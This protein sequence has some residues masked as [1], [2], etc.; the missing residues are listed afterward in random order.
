M[1]LDYYKILEIS[2]HATLLEIKRAYRKL[3]R[4][5][6]PD[7]NPDDPTARE[8]FQA[9][10][11]AYEVL[12]DAKKRTEYD[13]QSQTYQTHSYSSQ[14]SP[15]SPLTAQDYYELGLKKMAKRQ[16]IAAVKDYTQAIAIQPNFLTAYLQRCE[17][18]FYLRFYP[19][20]LE[21]CYQVLSRD[22]KQWQAYY[23]Q[24]R[25]RQKLGYLKAAVEAYT[26]AIIINTQKADLYYY[27]GL[28]HQELNRRKLA[29][30]DFI[31][32]ANLYKKQQN[33][34]GYRQAL[35]HKRDLE[36]MGFIIKVLDI[37]EAVQLFKVIVCTI[38]QVSLNPSGEI[39]P[40]FSQLNFYQ[41]V[42]IGVFY[43]LMAEVLAAITLPNTQ[44]LGIVIWGL[45]LIELLI[46]NCQTYRRFNSLATLFLAGL[47]SLSLSFL[48]TVYTYLSYFPQVLG[49]GLLI[50]ISTS[51]FLILYCGL[52]QLL[53]ISEQKSTYL[54]PII[55]LSLWGAYHFSEN[56]Q[57]F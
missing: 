20:V 44:W 43:G 38:F 26:K 50:F 28:T 24:G 23:Y 7:L 12:R 39:L 30:Q 18:Y 47:A 46:I 4:Q 35:R 15:A 6:H 56:Y 41:K 5:Y 21:D 45:L 25:V 14:A 17:A 49:V 57:S 3:A 32:A 13:Q 9:V 19:E 55:L 36:P 37:S 22:R 16:Y 54:M 51:S 2:P 40:I 48:L 11:A 53:N 1:A 29:R 8:K 34:Q 52:T 27:R 10:S 31:T 33:K 42:S